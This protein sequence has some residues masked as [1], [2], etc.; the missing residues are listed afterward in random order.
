MSQKTYRAAAIGHT[1]AGNYGHGLHLPFQEF[2]NI[3]FVAIADPDESGRQ[4]EM[5][6]AGV[7][8]GYADYREMLEK[9][10]LD[11][12]SVGP[13]WTTDHLELLLGCINAGCHVYSEKPMTATLAEG[14]QIVEAASRAGKK[15]AVAHQAV[16]LPSIHAVKGMLHDGTI[17]T[18]Q[19]IHAHGKQ[20]RRGGGEDMIV[21]GTHLF[22][23]MRFFVG[24][25]AWMQAHVTENGKEVTL[26]DAR[27]AT[28]PVGLI[29]GDCVNSYFA[30]ESGVSGLFD[31][32]KHEVSGDYYGMEIIGEEGRISMRGGGGDNLVIYPHPCWSPANTDQKWEALEVDDTPFSSGNNL[33]VLDL[34]DAIENDRK[35]ISAAEDAVA[36]LEMILGAYESQL[37]GKRVS[38]PIANREHPL[39]G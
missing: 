15:V 30:F 19:A 1:G 35:P 24:D 23:M 22:N 16:Y 14:D 32:R 29:A 8:Q 3:E 37:T 26:D 27:D 33:A 13:R 17:G 20:D 25:V 6:K 34:I 39:K 7:Q 36:A 11:I 10:D 18:V 2:D 31:T 38:F 12:V 21:L 5:E 4:E 9:E 28:E